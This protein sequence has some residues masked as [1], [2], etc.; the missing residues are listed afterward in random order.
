[1]QIGQLYEDAED[2]MKAVE[3]YKKIQLDEMD[4][5]EATFN[6]GRCYDKLK[7]PSEQM[8]AYETLRRLSPKDNKFRLAGLALLGEMYEKEGE[9]RPKPLP[10]IRTSLRSAPT[11]NGVR[12]LSKK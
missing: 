2:F 5:F 6:L 3:T 8:K 7:V 4:I 1:M 10:F 11:P 9:T 12:L